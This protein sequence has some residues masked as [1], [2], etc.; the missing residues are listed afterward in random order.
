MLQEKM[1]FSLKEK[2]DKY[3]RAREEL[4][5]VNQAFEEQRG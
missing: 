5:T 4:E 3:L 2:K 1:E